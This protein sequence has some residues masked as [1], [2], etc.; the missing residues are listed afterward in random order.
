MD[1]INNPVGMDAIPN[2]VLDPGDGNQEQSEGERPII[3]PL[4][5]S[6]PEACQNE[7]NSEEW[8][9]SNHGINDYL[10]ALNIKDHFN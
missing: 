10:K 2:P 3:F 7:L 5:P 9:Q 6:L 1:K 8:N 4:L